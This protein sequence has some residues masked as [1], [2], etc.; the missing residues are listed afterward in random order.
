LRSSFGKYLSVEEDGTLI[1]DSNV[2]DETF[3][4]S[5]TPD[6]SFL[7]H[8]GR[9]ITAVNTKLVL[10]TTLFVPWRDGPHLHEIYAAF[11]MNL[12]VEAIRELHV[13]TESNCTVLAT[14][15][16]QWADVMSNKT[17]IRKAIGQKFRCVPSPTMR[18]PTYKDFFEYANQTLSGELVLLANA[19]IEFDESLRLIA[20]EPIM[21]GKIGFVLSVTPPTPNG[22]YREVFGRDCYNHRRCSPGTY[23]NGVGGTAGRSWDAYVFASPLP[24]SFN[25]WRVNNVMNIL[26]AE[27]VAAYQFED[28]G[29]KLFNPCEHV[30]AF[31]WH[32]QGGKMHGGWHVDQG[33]NLAVGGL[34]P[35]W[36]CPGIQLPKEYAKREDLCAKGYLQMSWQVPGIRSAFKT[37]EIDAKVC[38]AHSWPC[39]ELDFHWIWP[40]IAAHDVNC[41]IWEHVGGTWYY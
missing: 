32:C 24:S 40:C 2:T 28:V 22:H 36:D 12:Q 17:R 39:K 5:T 19:D 14:R 34:L 20:P 11:L 10:L 9:L 25:V 27:N 29:I 26:G 8:E 31:H 13:M 30:H 38:C 23:Q 6:G 21:D 15:L 1:A 18:Q 37:P 7:K 33:A 35:C 41:V 3:M 16:R 4:L